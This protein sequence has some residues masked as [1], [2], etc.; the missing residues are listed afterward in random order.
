MQDVY[1]ALRKEDDSCQTSLKAAEDRLEAISVGQFS[2][3][4]G[5]S[6][7]L[8]D[9]IINSKREIA[10]AETEIKTADLKIK[11]NA[12]Q[13]KKKQIEMKKTEADYKRDSSSLGNKL[14]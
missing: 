9:Q 3:E 5:E 6:A 8:Q 11:N 1:D 10:A 14:Q 2:S 12:E 7:T 4:S 13:L